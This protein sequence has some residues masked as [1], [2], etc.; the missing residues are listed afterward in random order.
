VFLVGA[1]VT[2][3]V[4]LVAHG[5]TA[6]SNTGPVLYGDF[7]KPALLLGGVLLSRNWATQGAPEPGD[8]G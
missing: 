2:H 4:D 7:L 8:R 3:V 5:N 1:G 6:P